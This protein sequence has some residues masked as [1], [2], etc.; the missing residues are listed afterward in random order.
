MAVGKQLVALGVVVGAHG[1]RGELR[2]KLHNPES[3]LIDQPA[4]LVLRSGRETRVV[5]VE[6]SRPHRHGRLMKVYGIDDRDAALELRGGELCVDRS[7]FPQPEEG[8]HYVVDLIGF[9][10]VLPDGRELGQ[11][12]DVQAYPTVDALQVR[13]AEGLLEV[14]MLD[15]YLRQVD[16]EARRVVVDHI[17]DL[18]LE[19][20]SKRRGG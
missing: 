20:P 10:V 8:E 7:M 1:V 16:T 9:A 15:P 6:H 2:V 5:E 4:R 19:R 18:D 3:D 13:T 11:L 14:P 17:E 12:E